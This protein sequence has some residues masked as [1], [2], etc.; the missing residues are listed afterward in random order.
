MHKPARLLALLA[1]AVCAL[2]VAQAVPSATP[3]D[4]AELRDAVTVAGILE[5]EQAFQAIA[6]ANDDTR[7]ASTAGYDASLAYVRSQLDLDYFTITEQEFEFPYF[8]EL[9]TPEFERDLARPT[10]L[11]CR[12]R[13]LHHGLT[14]EAAT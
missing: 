1:V 6:D 7:A 12:G 5:H 11:R 9:T 14:P 8:E 4:S 10:G 2:V 13:L 3:T